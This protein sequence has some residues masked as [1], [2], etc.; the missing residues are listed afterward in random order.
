M[1]NKSQIGEYTTPDPISD[2]EAKYL[3]TRQEYD[4]KL[5]SSEHLKYHNYPYTPNSI[6]GCTFIDERDI[7]SDS[8]ITTFNILKNLQHNAYVQHRG[9]GEILFRDNYGPRSEISEACLNLAIGNDIYSGINRQNIILI[10]LLLFLVKN[11]NK[12]VDHICNKHISDVTRWL[13]RERDNAL[14]KA[15]EKL[16][17]VFNLIISIIHKGNLLHPRELAELRKYIIKNFK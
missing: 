12:Y 9:Y 10:R 2:I 4:Y 17:S 15:I 7:F 3:L 16:K 1:K 11:S 13:Y 5:S 8:E 14:E 6:Y